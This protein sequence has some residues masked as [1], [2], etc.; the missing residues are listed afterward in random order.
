VSLPMAV[1]MVQLQVV[2]AIVAT[3]RP[4]H[5]VVY[6]PGLFFPQELSAHRATSLLP[7]PQIPDLAPTRERALHLPEQA[8]LEV[9]FPLRVVGVGVASDLHLP[10]YP[11]PLRF[12]QTDRVR[13]SFAVP[14]GSREYPVAVSEPLE[15]F[16][17]DPLPGLLAMALAAPSPEHAKDPVI[18]SLEGALAAHVAVV[19]GPAFDLGVQRPDQFPRRAVASLPL[20]YFPDLGQERLDALLRWLDHHLAVLAAPHRLTEEI[21]TVFDT[22]DPGFLVGEFETPLGQE[23]RHERFDPIFEENLGRAGDDG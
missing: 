19:H 9:F 7:L 12:Q 14:S 23:L 11:H 13:P 16:L 3:V 10:H 4:P 5:P 6:V 17:L 18:D 2:Q 1:G 22:R 15:V 21:E 20:D 8:F